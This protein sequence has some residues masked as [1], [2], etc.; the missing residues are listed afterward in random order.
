MNIPALPRRAGRLQRLTA[1]LIWSAISAAFI[2]PGTV[3]TAAKAGASYGL[4]LVWALIFS[5]LACLTLQEASARVTIASGQPLGRVIQ[6]LSGGQPAV[7]SA[8][9]L[10]VLAGCAAYEMGNILGAVA[11]LGLMF[12]IPPLWGT[13]ATG[14]AAGSILWLGSARAVAHL[15]GVVVALMGVAFLVC[16]GQ[17]RPQL[18]TLLQGAFLPSF[19]PGAGLLVLGLVG[20]TVVPY[21]LFLGSGLAQGQNLREARSGMAVAIPLGGVISMSILITGTAVNDTLSFETLGTALAERLGDWTRGL[22]ALGLFAAGLSSAITAPLAAALSVRG[23]TGCRGDSRWDD[24][25]W[26]YRAVWGGVL[27]FGLGFGFAGVRP[28]PA[29]VLA[30]AL[31]GVLLPLVAVVLWIALND[32]LL[33]GTERLPGLAYNLWLG[34]CVLLTFVLGSMG[35]LRALAEFVGWQSPQEITFLLVACLASVVVAV[36]VVRRL[37]QGRQLKRPPISGTRSA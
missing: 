6:A 33:L 13:V 14:L 24:S 22:F 4:S 27:F 8:V 30:Q 15:L 37:R 5:T 35:V 17:L 36:P 26:R 25:A 16:A 19:T 23:V 3:T 1:V 28:V 9:L 12:N 7:P 2:G 32:R 18:G 34:T 31:N 10:A 20:T 29:I 21:N 11:G